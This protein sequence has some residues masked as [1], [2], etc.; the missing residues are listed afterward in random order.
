MT[1]DEEL[2]VQVHHALIEELNRSNEELRASEARYR[3][4]VESLPHILFV[5]DRDGRIE[6]SNRTWTELLGH[7]R[8]EVLGRRIED[9]VHSGDRVRLKAAFEG[10]GEQELQLRHANGGYR[11]L[12]LRLRPREDGASQGL[13]VDISETRSLEEELRQAS[14]MEAIGRLAGGV[15]HDF[16]NLLTVMSGSSD[17]IHEHGARDPAFILRETARIQEAAEEAAKL[18][19]QLLAISRPQAM[20][21]QAVDLG[22]EVE[23]TKVLLGGVVTSSIELEVDCRQEGLW[24]YVDPGQLTQVVLNLAIN[25]RD[26]MGEGGILKIQLAERRLET[27]G[28]AR[29]GLSPGDYVALIVED[30]GHGMEPSVMAKIFEP[31][32]TTKAPG[33]GTGFGLSTVY[34]IVKQSDGGIAVESKPGKGTRFEVLFP[35]IEASPEGESAAAPV[36]KPLEQGTVLVVEDEQIILDLNVS[37]LRAAGFDVLTA[38]AARAAIEVLSS[39]EF[40]VDLLITDM[41]TPD[42]GFGVE[43]LLSYLDRMASPPCVI[44]ASGHGLEALS[45]IGYEAPF[46][47]KPYRVRELVRLARETLKNHRDR[48]P[49]P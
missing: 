44:V 37:A 24:A 49:R 9:F 43:E 13:L 2:Q 25:A 39:D 27:L 16:N 34:A 20:E 28:A 33:R 1:R 4:L 11:W 10:R 29:F 30:D 40:S 32:F 19:G 18:T 36:A 45:E 46:L 5:V 8:E 21:K 15:A 17:L 38:K 14:K 48:A 26:A 6:F 22:A 3:D 7:E 31:F 42:D 23:K 41:V 12:R 35:R 47:Q